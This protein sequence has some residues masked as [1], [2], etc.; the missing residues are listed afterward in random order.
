MQDEIKRLRQRGVNLDC[1]PE[2][3][4]VKVSAN[5]PLAGKTVVITGTLEG[6]S[7]KEMQARLEAAGAKAAGSVSSKTDYLIAGEKAGSKLKKA[8]ELGVKILTQA[9]ADELLRLAT[10][11]S[12]PSPEARQRY[13]GAASPRDPGLP[14]RSGSYNERR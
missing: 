9:E 7:R 13:R 6:I 8:Q 2:D 3:G 11:R 14:S 4:P 10:A 5:S 12:R 1:L